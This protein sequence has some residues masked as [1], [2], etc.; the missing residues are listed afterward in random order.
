MTDLR[1][2]AITV[3]PHDLDVL[4]C[5]EVTRDIHVGRLHH[6]SDAIVQCIATSP[7]LSAS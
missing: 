7:K 5:L 4:L 3:E 2:M 6:G 1:L